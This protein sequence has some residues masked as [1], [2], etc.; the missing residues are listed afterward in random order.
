MTKHSSRKR[1]SRWAM[2]M[3]FRGKG[4]FTKHFNYWMIFHDADDED[5]QDFSVCCMSVRFAWNLIILNFNHF[6]ICVL[7]FNRC[8]LLCWQANSFVN[9]LSNIEIE[10]I[11]YHRIKTEIILNV[12]IPIYFIPYLLLFFINLEFTWNFFLFKL[13]KM[14]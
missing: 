7:L 14:N 9:K 6:F 5:D 2:K 3:F 11:I 1:A 10:L 8:L 12:L 4:L 13:Y